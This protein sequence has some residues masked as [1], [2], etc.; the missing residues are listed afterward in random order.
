MSYQIIHT[1][2]DGRVCILAS[3]TDRF[4]AERALPRE[5]EWAKREG[6]TGPVTIREVPNGA[7]AR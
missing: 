3:C 5:T 2:A 1:F 7:H 6:Y 4:T